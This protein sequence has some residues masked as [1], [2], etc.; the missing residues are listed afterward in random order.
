M[1][2]RVNKSMN[3][4]V[5]FN[6]QSGCRVLG[7][8]VMALLSFVFFPSAYAGVNVNNGNFYI[9]Y[10]DIKIDTPGVSLTITRTYNSRSNYLRG[11]FGVGWSS[12]LDT[13]I[14][15]DGGKIY[16]HEGGGGGIQAFD[17][18]DSQWVN[19]SNPKQN[20]RQVKDQ[21]VFDNGDGVRVTF[22]SAGRLLR[23]EDRNGNRI[24]LRYEN[25][26][27]VTIQDKHNNQVQITWKDFGGSPRVVALNAGD[28]KARYDYSKGGA[29]IQATGQDG[30]PYA[31]EYDDEYNMTRIA[32]VN[33]EYKAMGYNK[34]RDWITSFR[35]NDGWVTQ[36]S[37][38]SD[39]LDP[40]NRFGTRVV[41]F[42]EKKPAQK[43]VSRFW[44]EFK[45]RSDGT[46]YNSRAVSLI[47]GQVT[48]TN[49]TECCGT[50]LL[51]KQWAVSPEVA[52][53][54]TWSVAPSTAAQ[55]K[56]EYY[57][58]GLLKKKI[59][60]SGEITDL[61]YDS[62]FRK[63]A[64]VKV[65]NRRMEYN[66]DPKGNLSSAVDHAE[67]IRLNLSYDVSGRI[68]KMREAGMA[69]Q[70]PMIQELSF[71]YGNDGKPV[72]VARVAPNKKGRGV[73]RF[74]YGPQGEVLGMFGPAGKALST[75]QEIE[76]AQKIASAFQNLLMMVQPAGVS[77]SPE[78]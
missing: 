10:T 65:G 31:Y 37:Y 18:K 32:Y 57:A 73:I 64:S 49:L 35:D 38:E 58:D 22:N 34:T 24:E 60:S 70:A 44:Y 77:L 50:P 25:N 66:Y 27:P 39:N 72:E 42:E 48:E 68:V 78:G 8:I 4:S 21:Y 14:R 74:R 53:S 23:R 15:V 30:E 13:Y 75:D 43:N 59:S 52:N 12:D 19:A 71:R 36:Y 16:H 56:F 29:L 3:G 54:K 26:L 9:G 33:G 63:V 61:T 69:A 40:E 6:G 7:A 46:R 1:D 51:I 20:I 76:D 67:K 28:W 5:I 2:K 17:R 55:T 62:K 47:D 11:Y 41:R 45:K